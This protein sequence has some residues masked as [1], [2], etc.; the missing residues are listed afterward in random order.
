MNLIFNKNDDKIHPVSLSCNSSLSA[1]LSKFRPQYTQEPEVKQFSF[2]HLIKEENYQKKIMRTPVTATRTGDEFYVRNNGDANQSKYPI[3]LRARLNRQNSC[4]YNT[5][6]YK[7]LY[8][9]CMYNICTVVSKTL[10]NNRPSP[11]TQRLP[12]SA[13][14]TINNL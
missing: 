11:L 14:T 9:W 13:I 8:Y 6:R 1:T 7:V 5:L 12:H 10:S 3:E 2:N 4:M